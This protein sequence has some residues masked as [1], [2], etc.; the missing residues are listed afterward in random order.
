MGSGSVVST[1]DSNISCTITNGSASGNCSY[2]YPSG[3]VVTLVANGNGSTFAGWGG[4]CAGQG[5]GQCSLTLNGNE[6]VTASFIPP[7]GTANVCSGGQSTD[8]STSFPVSFNL[9]APTS[10]GSVLVVTQG[11]TGLDFT[12]GTPDTCSGNTVAACTVNVTFTP[13]A[14]GMRL[15]AVELVNN[16]TIIATQ[17]IYGVGQGPVA[18]FNPLTVF[19]RYLGGAPTEMHPSSH[20]IEQ[21]EGRCSRNRAKEPIWSSSPTRKF[22]GIGA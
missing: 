8:C 15:G 7:N 17:P 21:P 22:S 11:Y 19:G 6:S 20:P 12:E 4:A 5:T 16:G 14:V 2:G 18:A 13:Q 3:G 9:G 1:T 10:I